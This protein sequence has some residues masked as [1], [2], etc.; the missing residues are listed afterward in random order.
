MIADTGFIL[1]MF[2]AIREKAINSFIRYTNEQNEDECLDC[3]NKVQLK[4]NEVREYLE[5]LGIQNKNE[6]Q[7]MER[8]KRN[9]ILREI[10]ATEGVTIRQLS[11]ITGISKSVIDRL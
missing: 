10:K 3:D 7:Q 1:Q 8:S 4:D 9:I 11:R 2:S 6:L 5:K